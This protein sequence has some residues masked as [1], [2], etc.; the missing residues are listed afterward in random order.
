MCSLPPH[1]YGCDSKTTGTKHS[2]VSLSL[3]SFLL[4]LLLSPSLLNIHVI[5][6]PHRLICP[7][8]LLLLK[9][10]YK[11]TNQMRLCM[12]AV[13]GVRTNISLSLTL[14]PSLIPPLYVH[15]A[16]SSPYV[17]LYLAVPSSPPLSHFHPDITLV[18][19]TFPVDEPSNTDRWLKE[20]SLHTHYHNSSPIK[21]T[22]KM[23]ALVGVHQCVCVCVGLCV[24]YV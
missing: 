8:I 18:D 17:P 12:R 24:H 21:R 13:T 22:I 1:H 15:Y 6:I 19:E 2:Q 11:L 4:S 7:P 3:L 23:T 10:H 16:F 5:I 14:S 9:G 20:S